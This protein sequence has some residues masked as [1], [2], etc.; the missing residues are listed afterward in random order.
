MTSRLKY[1]WDRDGKLKSARKVMNSDKCYSKIKTL[2]QKEWGP[3]KY[4]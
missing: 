2:L 4:F 1:V 3:S